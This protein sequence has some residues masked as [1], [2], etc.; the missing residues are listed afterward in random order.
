MITKER[1]VDGVRPLWCGNTILALNFAFQHHDGVGRFKCIHIGS[2]FG[3]REDGVIIPPW[4]CVEG[5][6]RI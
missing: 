5:G 1:D 2:L 6:F 4:I 3:Q